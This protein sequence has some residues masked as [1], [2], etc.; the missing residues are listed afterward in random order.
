MFVDVGRCSLKQLDVG[1]SLQTHL[2]KFSNWGKWVKKVGTSVKVGTTRHSLEIG[3]YQRKEMHT[4]FYLYRLNPSHQVT[5]STNLVIILLNL[6]RTTLNLSLIQGFFVKIT[7]T[8]LFLIKSKTIIIITYQIL[9]LN[10]LN[11]IYTIPH[12]T[13]R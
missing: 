12:Q 6:D 4:C 1:R 9:I 10:P 3:T 2:G 7:N 13:V 8:P 5:H 11:N